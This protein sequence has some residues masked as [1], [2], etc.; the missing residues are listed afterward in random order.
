M[1]T[2]STM[3]MWNSSEEYFIQISQYWHATKKKKAKSKFSLYWIKWQTASF[4]SF[5]V[6]ALTTIKALIKIDHVFKGRMHWNHVMYTHTNIYWIYK[7]QNWCQ[8]QMQSWSWH[9]HRNHIHLNRY[10]FTNVVL[11]HRWCDASWHKMITI[12]FNWSSEWGQL[13]HSRPYSM[14][15]TANVLTIIGISIRQNEHTVWY[16][17][18]QSIWLELNNIAGCLD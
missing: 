7:D 10:H 9:K 17:T 18:D 2:D 1:K 13:T 4:H 5:H 3:P 16:R 11:F 14:H 12:N 15:Y 6:N 8:R